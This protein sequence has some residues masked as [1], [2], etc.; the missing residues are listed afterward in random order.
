MRS[1]FVIAL[2]LMFLVVLGV[3]LMAM[4]TEAV[5]RVELGWVPTYRDF[6]PL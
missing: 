1:P 6:L 5:S 2:S 4:A 3:M